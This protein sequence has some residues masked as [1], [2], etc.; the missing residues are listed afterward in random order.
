MILTS[1][2]LSIEITN[3]CRLACDKCARTELIGKMPIV[4]MSIETFTKIAKSKKYHTFYFGGTYGDCIYHPQFKEIIK[5]SKEN[6][7]KVIIHTNG[8]G[9]NIEWWHEIFKILDSSNDIINIAMDGYKETVGIYRVNFKEKDF[10]KNLEM[11]SIASN[12]YNIKTIWSFIPMNFNEH[13]IQK[14]CE[15]AIENNIIF[16]IK[17]S[18]RWYSWSD[19]KLPK[20]LKLISAHTSHSV[21]FKA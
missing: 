3:R 5:I 13:Q 14:A 7:I 10:Y 9:K 20:N 15:L 18:N 8:S 21:F 1:V 6:N 17:K 2:E 4:D 11:M 12:E 16:R 19:P